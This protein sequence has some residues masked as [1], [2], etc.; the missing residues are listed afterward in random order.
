MPLW[1]QGD[2]LIETVDALPEG[3]VRIKSLVLA[4]G[5]VTGHRHRIASK[6]A[7]CLFL[8]QGGP[9]RTPLLFMEVL[10]DTADV[11]HPEHD[12]ITLPRG[13]YR[14]WQQRELSSGGGW[15]TMAD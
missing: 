2:V 11:I 4:A 5:E 8:W 3:A 14:V 13:F 15:H 1:R 7:A 9:S 6:R 12:T 10:R